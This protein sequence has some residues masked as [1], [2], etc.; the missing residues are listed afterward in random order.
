MCS[1]LCL[2]INWYSITDVNGST[3]KYQ[4]AI[5]LINIHVVHIVW[6]YYEVNANGYA[7]CLYENLKQV[8][9]LGVVV[10]RIT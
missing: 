6:N 1:V 2:K 5:I 8:F 7:C 3:T 4:K 9:N 10:G